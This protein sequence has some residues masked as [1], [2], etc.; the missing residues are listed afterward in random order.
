MSFWHAVRTVHTKRCAS[1]HRRQQARLQCAELSIHGTIKA[2]VKLR[3]SQL[4]GPEEV[5][6]TFNYLEHEL[7]IMPGSG[8]TRIP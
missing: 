3:Q 6:A 5:P 7:K 2:A 8:S 1:E 4:E